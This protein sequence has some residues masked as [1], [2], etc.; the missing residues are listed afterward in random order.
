[1][2]LHT[3]TITT[4]DLLRAAK[5]ARVQVEFTS[6]GSRSRH[7]AFNVKLTGESRRRPN[8]GN[9]GAADDYAATWDQ[10]G[11][12]LGI[13]FGVDLDMK[14]WAYDGADDFN[15][16]TADRFHP[17]NGVDASGKRHVPADLSLY[18]PADAHGDHTFQWQYGSSESKCTKCSAVRR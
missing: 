13:L 5:A 11:V 16:K 14:C 8:G 17:Y 3:D 6:H 12:F 10:W 2:R 9:Y 15:W 7:H 1:M 4:A 18:W